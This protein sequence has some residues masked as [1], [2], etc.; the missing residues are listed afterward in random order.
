M[1]HL[2]GRLRAPFFVAL[3]LLLLTAAPARAQGVM[4]ILGPTI[5]GHLLMALG[6]AGQVIDAGGPTV[7]NGPPVNEFN[8]GT[9]PTGLGI[10]NSGL[11]HCQWSG[12]ANATYSEGC[13][14]FDGSGNFLIQVDRV[15]AGTPPGCNFSINGSLVPCGGGTTS[16]AA[17]TALGATTPTTVGAFMDRS[18]SLLDFGAKCDGTTDDG[19]KFT[20]AVAWMESTALGAVTLMPPGRTCA[21]A[22]EIAMAASA[23]GFVCPAGSAI[24]TSAPG[25]EIKWT[26][27]SSGRI[28]SLT[29]PIGLGK[30]RI[31]GNIIRGIRFNGNGGLAADGLYLGSVYRGHFDDLVFAGGFNGG[32][33]LNLDEVAAYPGSTFTGAIDTQNNTVDNLYIDNRGFTSD[34]LRLG[35]FVDADGSHGNTSYTKFRNTEIHGDGGTTGILSYGADNVTFDTVR[36]FNANLSVD[37]RIAELGA[38][39]GFFASNGFI[40]DHFFASGPV[41][42]RGTPQVAACVPYNAAVTPG[43]A[44]ACTYANV[45]RNIDR[46][47]GSTLPTLEAGAEAIYDN[48]LGQTYGA[49]FFGAVGIRPGLVVSETGST[50]NACDHAAFLQ[51]PTGGVYTCNTS[52]TPAYTFDSLAGDIFYFRLSGTNGAKDM[53]L[54][55]PF[56]TGLFEIVPGVKFDNNS[57]PATFATISLGAPTLPW[58]KVFSQQFLQQNSAHTWDLNWGLSTGSADAAAVL[59]HDGA[60]V[61]TFNTDLSMTIATGL[62]GPMPNSVIKS[63]LDNGVACTGGNDATTL[64]ALVG[65]GG[66]WGIPAGKTCHVSALLGLANAEL[67]GFDITS[68]IQPGGSV[69]ALIDIAGTSNRSRVEGLNLSNAS[70]FATSGIHY[71]NSNGNNQVFVRRNIISGLTNGVLADATAPGGDALDVSGNFFLNDTNAVNLANAGTNGSIHNNYMLTGNGILF[72]KA[73]GGSQG[74]GTRVYDNT[75]LSNLSGA[76]GIK[77][78]AGLE[79]S[80]FGNII[81]QNIAHGVVI[82]NTGAAVSAVKL[83]SNWIGGSFSVAAAQDGVNM[84]GTPEYIPIIADT[85]TNWSGYGVN[86][87]SGGVQHLPIMASKFY[88]NTT[89]DLLLNNVVGAT[90]FGNQFSSAVSWVEQ[91]TTTTVAVGNRCAAPA[92]IAAG[93]I[94]IGDGSCG[95]NQIPGALSLGAVTETSLV[96]TQASPASGAACTAGSIVGDTTYLYTCA[97][98]GV[99]KRVA[100]TGSY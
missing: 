6:K 42:L 46:T 56:G 22:S 18:I 48:N 90:L 16:L 58:Q 68:A 95:P 88:A 64:N 20:A 85:I 71:H 52:D 49:T 19:P 84:A 1:T 81:D 47:N 92:T 29:S 14:G 44:T 61:L 31:G 50:I 97:S 70:S 34:Q 5:N 94:V 25:C 60:P 63:V 17:V 79:L 93:S 74:E 7:T 45:F 27:A 41:M 40:F 62:T 78:T 91:G 36:V 72:A 54:Q 21:T 96:V 75:I 26:G 38:G 43:T 53:Q 73:G 12:Y 30:S 8:P 99:W 24:L 86:S 69:A 66:L 4:E 67:Y 87:G 65:A 39:P 11:G 28:M 13:T 77:I 82:D 57:E 100:M 59:S 55:H 51:G 2:R 37:L 32:S 35:N 89:G 3:A 33:A 83:I 9:L 10:V 15:G 23:E 76:N 80:I 98:T